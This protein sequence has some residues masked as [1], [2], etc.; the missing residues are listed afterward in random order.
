M[1]VDGIRCHFPDGTIAGSCLTMDRAVRN[2]WRCTG[3]PLWQVVAMAS[4]HPANAIGVADRKGS[5]EAG[6]DADIAIADADFNVRMT[7]VRGE[8]AY[9]A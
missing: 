8:C 5:L 6:K 7:F 9:R 2:F 1:I 4:I 3:L